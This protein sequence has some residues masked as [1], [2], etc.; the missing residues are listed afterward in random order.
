[1]RHQTEGQ[2]GW[3]NDGQS[4]RS[5]IPSSSHHTAWMPIP[6]DCETRAML[7]LF[8]SP[9]LERA[10][11][12]AQIAEQLQAKGYALGFREGHLVVLNDLDQPLCTGSD[13]G[14]PLASISAR[15]GRPCVKAHPGGTSGE[16]YRTARSAS[17]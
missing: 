7:R 15:I 4:G 6:L 13:L 17:A 11:S 14:I 10:T 3:G 1:M 5:A 2:A 12:W 8:L 9:I 16:L